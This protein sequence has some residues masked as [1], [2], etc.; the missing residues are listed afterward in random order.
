M[1]PTP[2]EVEARFWPDG[3][4]E[5]LAFRWRGRWYA[6]SGH[7]RQW[8]DAQGRRHFLVMTVPDRIWELAFDPAAGQWYLLRRPQSVWPV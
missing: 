8:E 3:R 6:I 4:V 5:P 1:E 2:I 7:G